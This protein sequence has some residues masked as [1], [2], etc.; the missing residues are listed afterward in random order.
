MR[1]INRELLDVYT[2]DIKTISDAEDV[3][4]EMKDVFGG[5]NFRM[6]E[7]W[8][9]DVTYRTDAETAA[10]KAEFARRLKTGADKDTDDAD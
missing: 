7:S 1:R 6:P 8:Y 5:D 10:E 9:G 3:W 4:M 2:V